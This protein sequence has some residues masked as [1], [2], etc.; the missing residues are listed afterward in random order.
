[1]VYSG[2]GPKNNYPQ[3]LILKNALKIPNIFLYIMV[4]KI[5]KM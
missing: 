5:I 3:Y 4:L 2:G 1:M